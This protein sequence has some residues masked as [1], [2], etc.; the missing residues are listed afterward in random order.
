M[1]EAI[2]RRIIRHAMGQ[3]PQQPTVESLGSNTDLLSPSYPAL[4]GS[5]DS[6]QDHVSK[7]L[8]PL[9]REET[10]GRESESVAAALVMDAPLSQ[11]SASRAVRQ[12]EL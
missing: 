6:P 2:S 3:K 11:P 5:L 1:S 9:E 10:R 12:C 8:C 4:L 7:F